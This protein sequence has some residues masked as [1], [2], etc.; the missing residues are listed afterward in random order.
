MDFIK[1]LSFSAQ[2]FVSHFDSFSHKHLDGSIS[3][4]FCMNFL[5]RVELSKMKAVTF[6]FVQLAKFA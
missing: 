4:F 5:I 1:L 2:Y 6:K 3:R